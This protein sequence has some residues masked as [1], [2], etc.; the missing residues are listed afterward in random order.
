[1]SEQKK[2]SVIRRPYVSPVIQ[3]YGN[4]REITK[5]LGKNGGSDGGTNINGKNFTK[6]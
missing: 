4:I 6:A 5:S 1:M 2:L 3:I